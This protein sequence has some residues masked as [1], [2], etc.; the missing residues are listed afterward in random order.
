MPKRPTSVY[1]IECM[2][3]VKIGVATDPARRPF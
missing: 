3:Y 1:I 2:G